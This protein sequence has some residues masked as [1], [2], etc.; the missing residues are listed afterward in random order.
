[1]TRFSRDWSSDVCSSDLG[2]EI[3][4]FGY[5][6]SAAD[7][8]KLRLDVRRNEPARSSFILRQNLDLND[9][10]L[11][12]TVNDVD[13]FDNVD[14]ITRDSRSEERRVGKECRYLC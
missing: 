5:T 14:C 2:Y 8:E 7:E 10:G 13:Q 6:L 11:T 12:E 3:R 1:H 9:F 4:I